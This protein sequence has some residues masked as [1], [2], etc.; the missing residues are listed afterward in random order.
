MLPQSER[1]I[2]GGMAALP[3]V[4]GAD[5]LRLVAVGQHPLDRTRVEVGAVCEDDQRRVDVIAERGEATAQARTRPERPVRARHDSRT[6]EIDRLG[7]LDRVGARD[8]DDLVD[9]GRAQAVE[10]V[11]QEQQLLR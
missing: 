6:L 10:D 1:A 9:R 2:N 7:R 5:E 4:G 8:D 3:V 11:G